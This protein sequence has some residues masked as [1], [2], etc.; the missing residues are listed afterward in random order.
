MTPA[1]SDIPTEA[2][3]VL[4][5]IERMSARIIELENELGIDPA[6]KRDI[7]GGLYQQRLQLYAKARALKVPYPVIGSAADTSGE[8]VRA[9]MHKHNRNHSP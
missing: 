6:H 7:S 5:E 8:S 3:P 4:A 2:Q 9:A 1:P